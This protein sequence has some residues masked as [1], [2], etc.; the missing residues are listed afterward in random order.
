MSFLIL[1]QKLHLPLASFDQDDCWLTCNSWASWNVGETAQWVRKMKIQQQ[2]F[3]I[4]VRYMRWPFSGIRK[5]KSNHHQSKSLEKV[6]NSISNLHSGS[7][8]ET[9]KILELSEQ[10]GV[11]K[12]LTQFLVSA[13]KQRI[14]LVHGLPGTREPL[15]AAIVMR[16]LYEISGEE[17]IVMCETNHTC[18][19]FNEI[20]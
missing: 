8:Q 14:N 16:G 20:V 5:T 2:R 3:F 1:F 15:F 10:C 18:R 9:K 7:E 17:V 4:P 19:R 11:D 13:L 12:A 6:A